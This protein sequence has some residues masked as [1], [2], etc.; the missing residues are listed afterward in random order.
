MR[1]FI[2][3]YEITSIYTRLLELY[4]MIMTEFRHVKT[5]MISKASHV[6]VPPLIVLCPEIN[7]AC[8]GSIAVEQPQRL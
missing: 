4:D 6:I 1:G 8:L 3:L 7:S 2:H 5:S